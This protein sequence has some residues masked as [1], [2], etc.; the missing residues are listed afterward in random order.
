MK[1]R[2][3]PQQA[4]ALVV[5][6]EQSSVYADDPLIGP[7]RDAIRWC[8]T[9]EAWGLRRDRIQMFASPQPITQP[10][11]DAWSGQGGWREPLLPTEKAFRDFIVA[12]LL[13]LAPA[14]GKAPLF[15]VWSGHGISYQRD[16]GRTRR[17]YYSDSTSDVALNLE[18][19]EL[20]AAL[21]SKS[22]AA[23]AQQLL[24]VDACATHMVGF[25]GGRRLPNATDFNTLAA[26]AEVPQQQVLLAVAPGQ[27]A[28]S[29]GGARAIESVA[30]FSHGLLD[31]L[32]Q[33]AG[34][35]W[36]DVMAAF[37]QVRCASVAL[38]EPPPV[39]WRLG[40][41]DDALSDGLTILPDVQATQLLAALAPVDTAVLS[42]AYR[43]ALRGTSMADTLTEAAQRRETMAHALLTGTLSDGEPEPLTRW[44][45]HVECRLEAVN[46]QLALWLERRAAS[47]ALL[48]PYR[49]RAGNEHRAARAEG[50]LCY[51]LV[52]EGP[53]EGDA[54][55]EP[56]RELR[57]WLLAGQPLA[58]RALGEAPCGDGLAQ[59]LKQLLDAAVLAA[60]ELGIDEPELIIELAL[61]TQRIDEAVEQQSFTVR[62]VRRRIGTRHFIVRRL[63]ERLDAL[64]R[65]RGHSDEV[66]AWIKSARKLRQRFEQHGLRIAWIAPQQISDGLLDMA[67]E[68]AAESSCIG[69]QRDVPCATLAPELREALM[70]DGLPF[71]CWSDAAW[72]DADTTQLH[73]DLL[74]CAG[75]PA[76]QRFWQLRVLAGHRE[77]PSTRLRLLWDDP[78]HNPYNTR[79]EARER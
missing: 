50:R 58:S 57:G 8:E 12:T 31:A 17:L 3:D 36:P 20:M 7:V 44:A 23:F 34:V 51:L 56:A 67:L 18:L 70:V 4:F 61:P 49:Q 22:F 11:L 48:A 40:V 53:G 1:L 24:V 16:A 32:P 13:T 73:D 59:A 30:R 77:H 29:I 28:G 2:G 10:L 39:D 26:G 46:L 37:E 60:Q 6:V 78:L 54:D 45:V 52:L 68:G 64:A 14:A 42:A 74:G 47:D 72:S 27:P 71:V 75:P 79:L 5:G 38:D 25:S 35:P 19:V 66:L 43:A 33:H 55:A 21:R 65:P 41:P 76:L 63:A 9:F 62:G 15:I 69:L